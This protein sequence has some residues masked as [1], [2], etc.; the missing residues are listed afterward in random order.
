MG[1]GLRHLLVVNAR[2]RVMMPTK[3]PGHNHDHR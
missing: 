2:Q 3:E 1:I